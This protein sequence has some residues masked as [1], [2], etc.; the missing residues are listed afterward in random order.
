MPRRAGRQNVKCLDVTPAINLHLLKRFGAN[1]L[2]NEHLHYEQTSYYALF[3][4]DCGVPGLLCKRADDDDN[5]NSR[6]DRDPADNDAAGHNDA[7]L[8]VRSRRTEGHAAACPFS[9]TIFWP[10]FLPPFGPLLQL[11]GSRRAQSPADFRPCADPSISRPSCSA[12]SRE[13]L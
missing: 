1:S 6:N 11:P 5:H 2:C 8:G 4:S 3:T 10:A 7:L 12:R 9:F 13:F